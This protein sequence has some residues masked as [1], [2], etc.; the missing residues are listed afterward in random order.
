MLAST[1]SEV[2]SRLDSA[3]SAKLG[4]LKPVVT[5]GKLAQLKAGLAFL[6]SGTCRARGC[7]EAPKT[8]KLVFELE[9]ELDLE[10]GLGLEFVLVLQACSLNCEEASRFFHFCRIRE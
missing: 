7:T 8:I 4:V 5:A 9:L 6:P 10:P 2:R 1:P 3:P